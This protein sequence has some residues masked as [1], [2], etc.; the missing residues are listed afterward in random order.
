MKPWLGANI[1][2]LVVMLITAIS[3]G[4][5]AGAFPSAGF[6]YICAKESIHPNVGFFVGWTSMLE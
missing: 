4:K 5:M 1:D 2:A 6:S 3:R